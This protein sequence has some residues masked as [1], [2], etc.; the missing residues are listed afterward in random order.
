MLIIKYLIPFIFGT[1][2]GSFLNVCIFR[3]P[4]K[5]SLKFPFSY[6]PSCQKPIKFYHNI[7]ILSYIFLRGKCSYCG[8]SISFRYFIVELL[9]GLFSLVLFLKFGL[10][11]SYFVFFAFCAALIVITFIDIDHQIIHNVITFPG[12][13]IGLTISFFLPGM[14][15]KDSIIGIAAGG[16]GFLLLALGYKIVAKREGMGMGD[17]KLI[18]MIGAFIG[19]KGVLVTIF[20]GSLFGALIGLTVMLKEKK[21]TKFAV[22]FGPFLAMGA[23]I[24]IFWGD[25]IV[26]H[27]LYLG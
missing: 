1:I 2:I 15:F 25:M 3:L 24:Y 10:S 13:V 16:G 9:T 20:A 23:I 17:I 27:F 8:E 11:L 14:A 18:S 5:E 6:C 12:I 26:R 22:P 21:D 19:L 4:K 7:P